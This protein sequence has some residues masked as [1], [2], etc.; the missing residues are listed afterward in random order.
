MKGWYLIIAGALLV[1]CAGI[2]VQNVRTDPN[3][4]FGPP[5]AFYV[6]DFSYD[7]GFKSQAADTTSRED[8]LATAHNLTRNLSGRL[9]T[10]LMDMAPVYVLKPTD[11]LPHSGYIVKGDIRILDAGTPT[12]RFFAGMGTGQTRFV[13]DVRVY[14]GSPEVQRA[15]AD[16][17]GLKQ[18][19]AES[20]LGRPVLAFTVAGG[21]KINSGFAQ[22]EHGLKDDVE[23]AAR[24]ISWE[25]RKHLGYE[26]N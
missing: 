14:R 6:Q 4:A 23:A 12:A 13:A 15:P 8:Y 10:E 3:A 9:R 11:P 5:E 22:W 1:G 21:S 24:K 16:A 2:D 20:A 7:R 25:I 26:R 17:K 19:G 18:A